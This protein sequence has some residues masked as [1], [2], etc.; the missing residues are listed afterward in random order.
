MGCVFPMTSSSEFRMGS[1]ETATT[2]KMHSTLLGKLGCK[3][4]NFDKT[5]HK[6]SKSSTK[7][8]NHNWSLVP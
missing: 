6:E 5:K 4:T 3:I 2:R 7:Q 8:E 1:I